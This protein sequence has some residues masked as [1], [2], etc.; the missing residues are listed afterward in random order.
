MEHKELAR[1]VSVKGGSHE[2]S[3][4]RGFEIRWN[5]RG[6]H[7][8]CDRRDDSLWRVARARAYQSQ[9]ADSRLRVVV[10]RDFPGWMARNCMGAGCPRNPCVAVKWLDNRSIGIR[11]PC[12]PHPTRRGA[13]RGDPI[14]NPDRGP[15][16]RSTFLASWHSGL[17]SPGLGILAGLVAGIPARILRFARRN[18]RRTCGCAGYPAGACSSVEFAV[19][20]STR[21]GL[22]HFGNRRSGER[23]EYG[24][25]QRCSSAAS[26]AIKWLSGCRVSAALV[27]A[28]ACAHFR[29]ASRADSAQPIN[30]PAA[31]SRS[32]SHSIRTER[33]DS[34]DKNQ[35]SPSFGKTCGIVVQW[36]AEEKDDREM[37]DHHRSDHRSTS[38][39]T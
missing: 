33:G 32:L 16:R 18:R 8:A 11:S 23:S 24:R 17:S 35:E 39:L 25:D 22:E 36:V 31:S 5:D 38:R 10:D 2:Y 15:G 6:Y 20:S 13:V 34:H 4:R 26:G 37:N 3:A 1:L 28:S 30:P 9:R 29:R 27:S 7:K 12:Y 14:G 19:R 21:V